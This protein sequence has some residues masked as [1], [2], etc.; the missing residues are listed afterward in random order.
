MRRIDGGLRQI[1]RERLPDAHW[2]SIES[3]STGSGKPDSNYCFSTGREGWVEYKLTTA[4][5]RVRLKPEQVGWMLARSERGG[6]V[7]IAVR[8]KV[9]AGKRRGPATDELW[10]LRGDLAD[11]VLRDGLDPDGE[12]TL[13]V[14]TGGPALWDW[15]RVRVL[16]RRSGPKGR[17]R[18]IAPPPTSG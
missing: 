5:R 14:E 7:T 11:V 9:P 3:P 2:A 4:G 10:I 17:G 12:A 8:R 16:L 1:F 6:L 18:R 13:T 15:R